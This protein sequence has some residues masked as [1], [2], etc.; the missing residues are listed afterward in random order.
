MH[1]VNKKTGQVVRTLELNDGLA[2][3]IEHI[4]KLGLTF[5]A[6]IGGKSSSIV[7][8]NQKEKFLT[9]RVSKKAFIGNKMIVR[10][11]DRDEVS[12]LLSDLRDSINEDDNRYYSSRPMMP[13]RLDECYLVDI[14]S[15]YLSVLLNFGLIT[16]KTYD[17]INNNCNK[18]A[19]LV[20]VGMLAARKDVYK[21]KKG[22][23]SEHELVVA[24]TRYLFNMCIQEVDDAM[25]AVAKELDNEYLFYWVDG[26]YLKTKEAAQRAMEILDSIGFK[27][28]IKKL[29]SFK[30]FDLP[31]IRKEVSFFEEDEETKRYKIFNIP[32]P[33]VT[34]DFNE[35]MRA[36]L[37]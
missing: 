12:I 8:Q 13:S 30:C 10:D 11:L 5:E 16:K 33:V 36:A 35:A 3:Y 14:N 15:A 29:S 2:R 32:S 37:R 21:F 34:R 1:R 28:K 18:K 24:E 23:Q 17:Y 22:E 9:D 7:F 4:R 20:A 19:R 27:T 31:A 26:I 25:K 6:H